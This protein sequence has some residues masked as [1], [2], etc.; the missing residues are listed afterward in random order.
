LW[1]ERRRQVSSID[2]EGRLLVLSCGAALHHARVTLDADGFGHRI[3]RTPAPDEPDHLATI[4][5]EF[6]AGSSGYANRR[7]AAPDAVRMFR[8]M[9]TRRIDRRPFA[10][11][12]VSEASLDRLTAAAEAHGA[13]LGFSPADT[14]DGYVRSGVLST[15][16][17]C[18]SDWLAAGE[19]YSAV[20]LTATAD[21]LAVHL[22][23]L[24][25][26]A[27]TGY[28]ALVV[29]IGRYAS[30]AR[31]PAAPVRSIPLGAGAARWHT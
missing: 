22:P 15:A 1:A 3:A 12:P 29:R 28:P 10:D 21:G 4:V 30:L 24:S 20:L 16:G 2:P 8:A 13:R 11:L 25:R 27:D 26:S 7:H 18:V 23:D 6:S 9:S 31:P 17:D 5:T 14:D 19:A